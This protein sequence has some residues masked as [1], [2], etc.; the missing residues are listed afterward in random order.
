[1]MT[2]MAIIAGTAALLLCACS[3]PSAGNG[4]SQLTLPVRTLYNGL[5]CGRVES[6]PS[7]IVVSDPAA[8]DQ[9]M[10]QITSTTIDA[11]RL[12][13]LDVSFDQ[14]TVLLIAMGQRPTAGH[15]LAL[16]AS[17]ASVRDGA[18]TVPVIWQK[19][20]SGAVTAQIVTSPCLLIAIGRGPY[21]F[22]HILDQNDQ[23]RLRTS[24]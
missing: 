10:T 1:M 24:I 13:S 17:T 6:S 15:G 23:V 9:V 11:N 21:S 18:V 4:K 16:G 20:T 14:E 2:R 5:H 7:L 19:P 22:I 8:L 3:D 12:S